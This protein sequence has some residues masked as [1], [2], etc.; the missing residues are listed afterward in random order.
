MTHEISRRKAAV[1]LMTV[2]AALRAQSAAEKGQRMI[3]RA[4]EA[5]GGPR[6]LAMQD[7][8]EA[9]RAYSFYRERLSGLARARLLTRYLVRPEPPVAGFLGVR[10]RQSFGKSEDA[11]VLLG[12]DYGYDVTYRGARPLPKPALERFKE[13]TLRNIF[14]ILRQRLGEPGLSIEARSTDIVDNIP[15]DTVE[16]IDADNRQVTVYFQQSTRLPV[17]QET[18]RREPGR[19]TPVQEVTTFS[20]YRDVGG[21]V[22]WPFVIQRHRDG[23]LVFSLYAESVQINQNLT[24]NLFTVPANIKILPPP[25]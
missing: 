3:D 9:G 19:P 12:E 4:L 18:T 11:Y 24:D 25:K 20:K 14:Y 2:P 17:K 21:G 16:I 8:I 10:E 6:F 22:L 7:R 15:C 1:L 5:L 23:E 13:T